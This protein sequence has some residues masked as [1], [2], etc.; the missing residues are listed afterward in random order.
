M[1]LRTPIRESFFKQIILSPTEIFK[2]RSTGYKVKV[3]KIEKREAAVL[4]PIQ[5]FLPTRDGGEFSPSAA[6]STR[7]ATR[8]LRRRVDSANNFAFISN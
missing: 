5:F 4:A 7:Q 2:S 6:K 3:E 8:T 1:P